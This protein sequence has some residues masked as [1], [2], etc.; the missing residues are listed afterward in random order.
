MLIYFLLFADK[1]LT[2]N[3]ARHF[4]VPGSLAV[5]LALA[6]DPFNQ[7]LIHNYPK[8][9]DDIKQTAIVAVSSDFNA[10]GPATGACR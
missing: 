4:A 8:L 5:I 9:V 7:N 10:L 1:M 2:I 3:F 6:F